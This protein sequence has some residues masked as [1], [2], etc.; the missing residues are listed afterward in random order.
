M[1]GK[2]KAT[3]LALSFVMASMSPVA[4]QES[5]SDEFQ[6]VMD[7]HWAW[8]LE[9]R[10]TFATSIGVRDYDDRIG[11]AAIEHYEAGIEQQRVFKARLDAIDKAALGLQERINYDLLSLN[12][13]NAIDGA[14]FGGKYLLLTN[15]YGPHTVVTRLPDRLPFF[16][17]ADYQSYVTRLGDIPRYLEEATETLTMGAAAG[18]VQPCTPMKRVDGNIRFHLVD[19][20]AD[21]VFL[22]PFAKKPASIKSRDWKKLEKQ[23]RSTVKDTVLPALSAYADFY[24]DE[25]AGSCR[26]EIGALTLPDGAEYYAHR[27]KV[28]TTTDQTPDD[29]H[30]LGLSEVKRIRKEIDGVIKEVDFKGDFKAF[31]EFL[32]TDPQFY[33]KT[34]EALLEKTAAISKKAD[35]ELPNLFTKLPRMPYT[36]KPVPADIAEGATTAYYERPAGDG[37]RAGV[38]RIN[39]SLLDQRPIF[40]LEALSLHEAVPGH[41]FQI[42]LSQ[43]LTLP[44]F[45]KYGG[46]TAFTEGWGL[47]AESLGLDIGFYEDPYQNFGRLSYEMW[48]A[49]RL[50]VDT[51]MHAKGWTRQQA[52]DFMAENTALSLHNIE[53]EVD[54]YITWPGQALAY[55]M[56]QLK[57]KELRTRASKTLGADFDL[58]RFHDAVLE[59]GA[60]PLSLLETNMDQWIADE[61]AASKNERTE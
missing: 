1:T 47:Y 17:S 27:A 14:A 39:T 33:V 35:G 22:K 13:S 15:R 26:E 46:F 45:R 21:S 4:A 38:Y 40:E 56:G 29:I 37:S 18:W 58:R 31:Q 32:R 57:I 50:V 41:H 52:I 54:R 23:A 34:E 43:E 25:Y 10:P 61:K 3:L 2:I 49:C 20:V 7:E 16:T 36:V 42:A 5:A 48:R 51:G 12:I 30:A 9:R 55:K 53:S 60:I 44:A 19:D 24:T 8:S 59:N 28:F 11:S 6:A